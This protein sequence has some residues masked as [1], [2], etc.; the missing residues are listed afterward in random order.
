[1]NTSVRARHAERGLTLI[2]LLITIVIAGIVFAA[3]VPVFYNALAFSSAEKARLAALN[4]AQDKIEKIRQLDYDQ[5]T[6]ANLASTETSS[7]W[8]YA[9]EFGPTWTSDQGRQFDVSYWVTESSNSKQIFVTVDWEAP[10]HRLAGNS[11]THSPGYDPGPPVKL[12]YGA[13]LSTIIYRQ[14]GGA[15]VIDLNM[16]PDTWFGVLTWNAATQGP[17]NLDVQAV[18]NPADD[19]ATTAF[20]AEF[21]GY[22]ANDTSVLDEKV[23]ARDAVSGRFQVTWSPA[24]DGK[25]DGIYRFEVTVYSAGGYPGN[26]YAEEFRLESGR[27]AA[28][29]TLTASAGDK[30][31]ALSWVKSPTADVTSYQVWRKDGTAAEVAFSKIAEGLVNPVYN[32]TIVTNGDHYQYYVIAV[33]RV[34]NPSDPSN[35]VNADPAVRTD[36]TAPPMPVVTNVPVPGTVTLTWPDV[37]DPIVAGQIT[38]GID[39]YIVTRDDGAL[40]ST[41]SPKTAGMTVVF[42][43]SIT[44]SHSYTVVAWDLAGNHSAAAGPFTV[45]YTL[46]THNLTVF[47]NKSNITFTVK[48]SNN[49]VVETQESNNP[50]TWSLP[51]G[52]YYVTATQQGTGTVRGPVTV[53]LN[54]D[55]T[56]PAFVFQ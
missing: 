49:A 45:T 52:T 25:I 41:L 36:F 4:V 26:S 10:P 33:D 54:A 12:G 5:I 11:F 13:T 39:H 8:R 17:L 22:G 7:T 46:P 16:D 42:A 27:P 48:D 51:Q 35:T 53:A 37:V 47:A 2:E 55:Q 1:M 19:N 24:T 23:A 56:L 30:V 15:Q 44:T 18:L 32:D 3:A 9:A 6:Q 31:V 14:Y 28:A 50:V 40:A 29:Q 20:R 34:L 21:K 43:E 38:S